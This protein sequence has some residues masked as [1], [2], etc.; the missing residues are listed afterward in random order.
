MPVL[1]ICF[2]S[3]S[4]FGRNCNQRKFG[5]SHISKN[6]CVVPKQ[7]DGPYMKYAE[8]PLVED[9][10]ILPT[11]LIRNFVSSHTNRT[12]ILLSSIYDRK[13]RNVKGE[14]IC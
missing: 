14:Y 13:T 7:F 9:P 1:Y 3:A 5:V 11:N 4:C 2:S 8:G 12:F 6:T 10:R